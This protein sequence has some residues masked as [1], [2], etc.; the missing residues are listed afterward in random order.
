MEE[1]NSEVEIVKVTPGTGVSQGRKRRGASTKMQATPSP[2]TKRAK[3]KA[4]ISAPLKAI[5]AY[6][7]HFYT[8]EAEVRMNEFEAKTIMA[9]KRVSQQ[10]IEQYN[11]LEMLKDMGCIWK[12]QYFQQNSMKVWLENFMQTSPITLIMPIACL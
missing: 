12:W 5:N 8:Q 9:E 4:S 2:A 7:L 3:G 1:V 11:A 6:N 10:T